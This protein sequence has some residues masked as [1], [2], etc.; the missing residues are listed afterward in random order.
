MCQFKSALILKD[1]IYMSMEDSHSTLLEEL[2]IDDTV[3]NAKLKFVRA[4]LI[5]Y[6]DDRFSNVDTWRFVI[7]QDI[8]PDWFVKD[9]DEKRMRDAVKEW[10]G[11]YY[12]TGKDNLELCG[13]YYYLK[14]CTNVILKKDAKV[15]L[16]GNSS[17]A[18]MWDNSS[19]AEM[20]DNSTVNQMYDNS[21][22]NQMYDNSTVNVMRYNSTINAMYGNSTVNVMYNNSTVNQMYDNSTVNK[23]YNNS[24]SRKFD[25]DKV[26]FIIYSSK[27]AILNTHKEEVQN[28]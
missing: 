8:R 5:P 20:R 24:I 16:F 7:D 15:E 3:E 11:K 10:V 27:K 28:G 22:V 25:Y 2:G 19:V 4:E 18:W 13:E 9:Y 6:D 17:V 23:M 14:D 1:K 21:T 12:L 26:K